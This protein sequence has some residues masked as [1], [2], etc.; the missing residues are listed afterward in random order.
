MP[1]T[2]L[3]LILAAGNGSR[4]AACSGELPKP[5]VPLD[6][7]PL[8]EHVISGAR[9]A[10]VEKFVIVVGY[11]GRTIQEWYE[12]RPFAGID[13]TWVENPDYRN[14]NNGVSV[15]CAKDMIH[16]PFLLLMADHIFEPAT[17]GALL[18]QPLGKNEVILGVDRKIKNV[19]DLD[20]ATKVRL[21]GD[22]IVDIGKN[23]KRYN[24][25]DTG[26]F[27]CQPVLFQWLEKAMIDGNCSLSDG[28]RT[29]AQNRTF[30]GFDIGAAH[31]QD[32]DT[33]AAL[34]YA[35][36]SF[37]KHPWPVPQVARPVYA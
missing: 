4:L 3:A 19:F 12:N 11:R 7:K 17:A 15:F 5:L 13:V 25:L 35:R 6:G 27:L 29:M 1:N 26:M 37:F 24:A 18:R 31:W 23:L 16:E 21:E 36:D 32:V 30:K 10:G 28:L 33:P 8:L 20:D 2:K 9:E 22:C 34:D 14:K